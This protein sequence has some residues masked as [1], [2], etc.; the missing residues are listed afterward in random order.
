MFRSKPLRPFRLDE[1]FLTPPLGIQVLGGVNHFLP[2]VP[3]DWCLVLF[4]GR[5]AVLC[6][7]WRETRTRRLDV[8]RQDASRCLRKMSFR[9]LVSKG[10]YLY[11]RCDFVSRRKPS[12][13]RRV[14]RPHADLLRKEAE[15]SEIFLLHV[16]H[17]EDVGGACGPCSSEGP[18]MWFEYA[19]VCSGSE[20]NQDGNT[21][22]TQQSLHVPIY[23]LVP[24]K[25]SATSIR[26]PPMS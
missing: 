2:G 18:A 25:H 6:R 23:E 19:H 7:T 5:L 17:P 13:P 8:G 10:I 1:F 16:L 21:S 26:D 20:A 9:L 24:I 11:C 14:G 3:A 12:E 4:G 22:G 15:D